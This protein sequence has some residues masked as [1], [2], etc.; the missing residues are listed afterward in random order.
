MSQKN[1]TKIRLISYRRTE[2]PLNKHEEAVQQNSIVT[3][4]DVLP[5]LTNIIS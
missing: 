2:R 3:S 5:L 1:F 4:V